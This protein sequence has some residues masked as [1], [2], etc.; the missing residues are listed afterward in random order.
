MAKIKICGLF[1]DCDIDYVNKALPDYCGFIIDF[2]KSHRSI[3]GDVL[4]Q[5]L[6]KLDKNIKSVCVFVNADIDFIAEFNSMCDI[7]QLHGNEDNNYIKELKLKLP[8][9]K[10][11]KAFKI[12]S[13]ADLLAAKNSA[14]DMVLL[15]NGYGTGERFDWSL[16]KELNREFVLA[17]G[18][19]INNIEEAVN[20]FSPYCVDISSGVESNKLKNEDKINCLVNIMRKGR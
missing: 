15:D 20:M 16:I 5:L 17:G 1:R 10:V 14:A 11:W 18:L 8:D 2:P 12:S 7:I 3:S 6:L 4:S 13:K 19:N 9:K